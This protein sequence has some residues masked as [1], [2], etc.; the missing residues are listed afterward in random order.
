MAMPATI[1]ARLENPPGGAPCAVLTREHRNGSVEERTVGP[2]GR[3]DLTE[4]AAVLG[5][6]PD[7]VRRSIRA[8]LLDARRH[9]TRWVITL[10]ACLQYLRELADDI[11]Y[12]EAHQ[13]E[14]TIPAE[15]VYR[16]LPKK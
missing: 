3:L 1:H 13:G 5:E 11:A 10:Q 4:A 7:E 8:G 9:G 15:V 12:L 2:R 16:S 14:P 6:S